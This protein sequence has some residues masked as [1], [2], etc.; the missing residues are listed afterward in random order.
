MRQKKK[1]MSNDPRIN[2]ALF[3]F[4]IAADDGPKGE[5]TYDTTHKASQE[6]LKWLKQVMENVE[7]PDRAMKRCV[8][9]LGN[10]IA[11]VQDEIYA[12]LLIGQQQNAANKNKNNNNSKDQQPLLLGSASSTSAAAVAAAPQKPSEDAAVPAPK[13][14][15][16][17][18]NKKTTLTSLTD[19][20]QITDQVMDALEEICDKVEDLNFAKEFMLMKGVPLYFGL[21]RTSIAASSQNNNPDLSKADF[22]KLQTK[23]SELRTVIIRSLAGS[24]ANFEEFQDEL[25]KFHFAEVFL[26]LLS[27]WKDFASLYPA[28]LSAIML[29]LTNTIRQHEVALQNF[30]QHDGMYHLANVIQQ[31]SALSS[32]SSQQHFIVAK[33]RAFNFAKYLIEEQATTSPRVLKAAVD[34]LVEQ[35]K[36][37][38]APKTFSEDQADAE[39]DFENNNMSA[40]FA[41]QILTSALLKTIMSEKAKNKNS[42]GKETSSVDLVMPQWGT[43]LISKISGSSFWENFSKSADVIQHVDLKEGVEMFVRILSSVKNQIPSIAGAFEKF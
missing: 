16:T 34:V 17:N 39:R 18:T 38:L 8:T 36:E 14:Q 42:Q 5:S 23:W 29:F 40:A 41:A 20:P 31:L 13:Q 15:E 6:D 11:P 30:L 28:E 21:V 25:C 22:T 3:N 27:K 32:S 7:A 12:G 37:N 19:L 9:T 35:S 2:S 33:R 4:C 1:K 10:W 24:S 43:H 26:P